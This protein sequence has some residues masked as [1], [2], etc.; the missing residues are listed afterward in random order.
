[1]TMTMTMARRSRLVG[2]LYHFCEFTLVTDSELKYDYSF[3]GSDRPPIIIIIWAQPDRPL[4]YNP[5]LSN[6][7]R[8]KAVDEDVE[9]TSGEEKVLFL[10]QYNDLSEYK[11]EEKNNNIREIQPIWFLPTILLPSSDPR[12]WSGGSYHQ[13]G[14]WENWSARW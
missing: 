12:G 6:G 2:T 3:P 1:M 10:Q 9:M 8:G 11:R 14:E 13:R 7:S 5:D 4:V